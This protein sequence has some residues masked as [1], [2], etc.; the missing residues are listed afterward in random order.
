MSGRDTFPSLAAVVLAVYKGQ[1]LPSLFLVSWLIMPSSRTQNFK[2]CPI[3]SGSTTQP[4][5]IP[6]VLYSAKPRPYL[7]LHPCGAVHNTLTTRVLWKSG[8]GVPLYSTVMIVMLCSD[9]Y[10]LLLCYRAARSDRSTER[11]G[12]GR[13]L[14]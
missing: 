8:R 7:G 13:S 11:H 3:S 14:A 2:S 1:C 10:D 5:P 4:S 12:S 9:L 6:H